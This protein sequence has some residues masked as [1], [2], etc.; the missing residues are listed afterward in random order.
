MFFVTAIGVGGSSSTSIGAG[1]LPAPPP[2]GQLGPT[3][4]TTPSNILGSWGRELVEAAGLNSPENSR[5]VRPPPPKA[6]TPTPT[7][8]PIPNPYANLGE[9]LFIIF[10]VHCV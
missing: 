7:P 8:P 1:I 2:R 4:S 5:P 9:F 10:F 6:S 3:A